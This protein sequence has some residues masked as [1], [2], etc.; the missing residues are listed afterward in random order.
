MFEKISSNFIL[1]YLTHQLGW[2]VKIKN[3]R[4]FSKSPDLKNSYMS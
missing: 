2:Y 4:K 1:I 3:D